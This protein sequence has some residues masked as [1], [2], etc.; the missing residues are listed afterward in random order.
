MNQ[1]GMSEGDGRGKIREEW[2]GE[3]KGRSKEKA[4]VKAR[5]D[6]RAGIRRWRERELGVCAWGLGS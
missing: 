2:G 3:R 4:R 6:I 1:R 5:E